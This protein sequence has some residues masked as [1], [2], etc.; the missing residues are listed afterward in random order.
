MRI[1]YI[2]ID[3]L[4]PDHPHR[5]GYHPATS[6]NIDRIAAGG[7]RFESRYVSDAPCLPSR[8]ALFSGRFGIH[9][10][11]INGRGVSFKRLRDTGRDQFAD[12]LEAKHVHSKSDLLERL[13]AGP[14]GG[15]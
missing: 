14:P 11:A 1:P 7:A 12:F 4:R 13:Q 2:D 10:G 9:T 15:L 8:T 5:C 3:C 6:P